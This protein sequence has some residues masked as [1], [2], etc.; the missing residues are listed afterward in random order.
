VVAGKVLANL[1]KTS[2]CGS[3]VFRLLIMGT[4][5]ISAA[6]LTAA[7]LGGVGRIGEQGGWGGAGGGA[8]ALP[9]PLSFFPLGAGG[10]GVVRG[11]QAVSTFS[12]AGVNAATLGMVTRLDTMA[13]SLEERTPNS[14]R[15]AKSLRTPRS[16]RLRT[17]VRRLVQS[18]FAWEG[19]MG[20]DFEIVQLRRSAIRL[21]ATSAILKLLFTFSELPLKATFEWFLNPTP[22]GY[23][24]ASG[25]S[26]GEGGGSSTIGVGVP[27]GTGVEPIL[28]L[29]PAGEG[30]RGVLLVMGL[31][32][33]PEGAS[34]APA[35]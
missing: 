32:E 3:P 28:T 20:L 33:A 9:L 34:K 11:S 17:R 21:R 24:G 19:G 14:S 26:E 7:S 4:N 5:D 22:S 2:S 15:D 35:V 29:L 27:S 6:S 13:P 18:G 23:S 12:G 16:D 25:G 31:A 8:G 1:T 10:T 30:G